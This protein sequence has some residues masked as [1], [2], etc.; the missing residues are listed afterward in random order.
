MIACP[1]CNR[2]VITRRDML[3]ANLD[4]TARCRACGRT[5][6]VDL[7]GRWIISCLLVMVLATLLLYCGLFYSGHL[8][9]VSIVFVL[10]GW[11]A[12]SWSFAPILTLEPVPDGS[13]FNRRNGFAVFVVLLVAAITI[14]GVMSSRFEP[15]DAH[16][17]QEA[18][19]G[20]PPPRSAKSER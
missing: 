8:F 16:E 1:T 12:L 2:R 20:R 3:Y 13:P 15:E 10:G 19:D 6:R 14:D 18:Q 11:R 4:G 17:A 5:A 7:F 9:F